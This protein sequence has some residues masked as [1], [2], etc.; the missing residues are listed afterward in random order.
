MKIID[1]DIDKDILQIKQ[2]LILIC[3][4]LIPGVGYFIFIQ[5][6]E[7]IFIYPKDFWFSYMIGIF[8]L[9]IGISAT[10]SCVY[11]FLI[12]PY[13]KNKQQETV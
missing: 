5:H 11:E 4:A 8:H 1:T 6:P 10:L 9:I 13:L 12:Y 7:S 2:C 3:C